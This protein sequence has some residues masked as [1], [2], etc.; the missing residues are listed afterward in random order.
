MSEGG[1]GEAAA[2]M[3]PPA[4]GNAAVPAPR[5]RL[6][7]LGRGALRIAPP[8][9]FTIAA[10]GLWQLL[11]WLLDVSPYVV[12]KPSAV[13]TTLHS[14]W[15]LLAHSARVTLVE[16]LYGFGLSVGVGVA[17]ALVLERFRI[18][19]RAVYPLV[20]VFQNV[21]KIAIAPLLILWFGFGMAPKAILIAVIAFFPITVTMRTGLASVH[22]DLVLLLRSVGASRNEILLRVQ[23]PSAI[24]FLIAG[25]HV[26]ITLSV[27]G[28]IVAEFAGASSGLGY[29][30]QYAS[31]QLDTRL[32][33]AGIF[34][35]S[36]IGIVLYYAISV[37]EL[38]LARRFPRHEGAAG[39]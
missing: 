37:L 32:V 33:F 20:I 1:V 16:I 13:A 28:A 11:V 3:Q 5:R 22:A 4:A 15:G 17:L 39:A 8:I 36:V 38:A 24:P 34:V 31:T 19:D 12:P 6:A 2:T 10:I 27:I 35:I 26:A 23:I 7:G 14:H 21:P 25:L 18:L 30:I 9:L 29:I